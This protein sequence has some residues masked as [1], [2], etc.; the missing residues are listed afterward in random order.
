MAARKG[1]RRTCETGEPMEAESSDAGT[2]GPTQVYLP[3]RG[4][5]LREGEELVMDEEAYVLYHRAQTGAPCLSFDIVRDHLGD[6]RTEL[7]LTLYLCAGTQAES[8][9][10][11]RLMVLRM[12]NLH[13]TKPPPSEGS[14]EEE[15]EEDE[16][17]EEERKPQLELA[18]VPHYGGIN[19]VRVS[20]LGE[21]PVAGIWSEKGQVEV[22]ALRRLLQVVDDPQALATFLRD[23]Q[24]RVKPIFAFSG[25]MGEGFALDW[26]PRVSGRL[27]TGDCQKN[28]HLW[29]PTDGGS[30]H[31]D[32]RPFVGHTRSVEDLQWSPTED[33]VFAS[34]SADA[35]IRI[36]DIR[37]APSKACMLTAAAAHDGDVNV[38]SWSRREPFLLSG[39]DDGALKVW[40][41]RQF[42]PGSCASALF[43][44]FIESA[45]WL[46]GGHLQ[47]ARGP[48]DL[49]RVAPPG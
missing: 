10:S 2:E 41:L 33:T 7:P 40:D 42:K 30:W 5:P 48:R 38:I 32:Q 14:D 46:P 3:G 17:D 8:A 44:A 1:R 26:S 49:S 39:G 23:E 6:N 25:H 13:G 22:Y 45:V 28:I 20:W 47:A 11:N 35:S 4:P 21:E 34:C 18:M 15:E 9:Q 36:W 29:T 12:H 24:A 27:L 16:E 43:K 37:A 31:V 19:R